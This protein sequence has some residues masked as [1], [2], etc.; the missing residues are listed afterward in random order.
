MTL[1]K[2]RKS[3]FSTATPVMFT[4]ADVSVYS[5]IKIRFLDFQFVTTVHFGVKNIQVFVLFVKSVP[6]KIKLHQTGVSVSKTLG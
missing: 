6:D 5:G 4:F 1:Q 2:I 3:V